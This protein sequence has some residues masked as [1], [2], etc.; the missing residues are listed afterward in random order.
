MIRH[1]FGLLYTVYLVFIT[2]Q[3]S[4][5]FCDNRKHKIWLKVIVYSVWIIALFVLSYAVDKVAIRL[6][7]YAV[8]GMIGII[9]LFDTSIKKAVLIELFATFISLVSDFISYSFSRFIEPQQNVNDVFNNTISYYFGIASMIIQIIFL[10]VIG[11]IFNKVDT[12]KIN[13]SLWSKYLLFPLF[14]L[15]VIGVILFSLDNSISE[16]M[17][18]AITVIAI[19]L[20]VMNMYVFYFLKSDINNHIEVERLNMVYSNADEIQKMY[21]RLSNERDRLGKE[22]HEFRNMV[23]VWSRLLKNQEYTKLY[24]LMD[25]ASKEE[26]T[27][28]NVFFTGNDTVDIILNDKFIEASNKHINFVADINDLAKMTIKDEEII[29]LLS[30]ALNN[31]IEACEVMEK[32]TIF[33]KI[34]VIHGNFILSVKNSFCGTYNPDM[35]TTKQDRLHHGYGISNMKSI[36]EKYDGSYRTEQK[37]NMFATYIVLPQKEE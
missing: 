21:Q 30:N 3:F 25:I 18:S 8:L 36:V 32:P 2:I 34:A 4:H 13:N 27:H 17:G 19:A 11:R 23:S 5:I 33:V 10:L 29:I 26:Q 24:D 1:I 12:K 37:D 14:S 9:I 35:I 22:N 7:I 16:T 15:F 31:A 20:A 6:P 28:T